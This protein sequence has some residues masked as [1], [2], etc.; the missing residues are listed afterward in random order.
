MKIG[1]AKMIRE[2]LHLYGLPSDFQTI[3]E[4]PRLEWVRKVK[5][6]I[7]SINLKRLKDICHKKV[8]ENQEIKTKTA[9]IVPIIMGHTYKREP[10]HTILRTTKHETKQ[11]IIARYGLLECGKN[12]KGTLNANCN[13]CNCL[14]DEYH[15]IN[16]CINLK[17]VN[18]FDT[19]VKVD[20]DHVYS[21]NLE[22]I[23]TVTSHIEKIWNTRNACGSMI[24]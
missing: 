12:F 1:W 5:I 8:G 9:S 4:M 13:A 19:S 24:N 10:Q 15:R 17:E 11:I 23:R 18:L 14:D 2:S 21:N 7:E 3:K 20:F 16:M 6:A 22:Q